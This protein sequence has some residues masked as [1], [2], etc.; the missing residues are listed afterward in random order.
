MSSD[1]VFRYL[2]ESEIDS[3]QYESFFEKYHG[4]GSFHS[5]RSKIHWYFSSGNYRIL[6]A[7]VDG[8]YVGQSSSYMAKAIVNG[9]EKDIWWSIDT[10]VL[11]EMRGRSLGRKLQEKLH[12]DLPNFSSVSY[13]KLNG[14]IKRKCGAK[15]F[16]DFQF[17]YYPISCYFTLLFELS[18]KK[19]ISRT[20]S[21]PKIRLPFFYLKA[22]C[23]FFKAVQFSVEEIS[24][25]SFDED[26]SSFMEQ[27]LRNEPFHIVRSLHYLKWKYRDNPMIS[28]HVLSV[29]DNG[30][31]I[32]I[33]VLSD[34]YKGQYIV[35]NANL[36]KV[37]DY[38]IN[39]EYEKFRTS[40]FCCVLNY[41]SNRWRSIPDGVLSAQSMR[42][43]PSMTYPRVTHMLS[44]L[45]VEKLRSGYISYIDQDMERMY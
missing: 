27:C 39:P 5:W 7:I 30:E 33:I 22:N 4:K 14:I 9:E 36:I 12:N 24:D 23:L 11:K 41:C 44:T 38:V 1:I 15:E 20:I 31:R 21:F 16:L 19:L 45:E 18:L 34:V 37:Y 26:I 10:F 17:N 25:D 43:K 2:D 42:Y 3:S 6:V 28:F 13:S 32:G 29:M 40:I 35:T 8:N